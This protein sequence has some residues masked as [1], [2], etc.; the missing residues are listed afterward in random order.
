MGEKILSNRS[1]EY[2]LAITERTE[3][4]VNSLVH[5]GHGIFMQDT[6]SMEFNTY[7]SNSVPGVV[8]LRDTWDV[9]HVQYGEIHCGTATRRTID[10][11]VPWWQRITNWK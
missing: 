8:W 6:G 2:I 1:E 5:P 10:L 4:V 7:V 3:G 11:T 9:Y